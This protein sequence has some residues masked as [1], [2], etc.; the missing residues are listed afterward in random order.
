MSL[1]DRLPSLTGIL[2]IW[3][4]SSLTKS[5]LC[6]SH[7]IAKAQQSATAPATARTSNL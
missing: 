2:S 6:R 1:E 5:S 3:P 7:G 4:F